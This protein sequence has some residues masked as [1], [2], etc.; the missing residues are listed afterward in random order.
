MGIGVLFHF[1]VT[2]S[3]DKDLKYHIVNRAED[4]ESELGIS[5]DQKIKE[6][7][8]KNEDVDQTGEHVSEDKIAWPRQRRYW[9]L[10]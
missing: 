5:F 1:C 6:K 4:A 9:E 3:K 10:Q 7:L 8:M 2:S